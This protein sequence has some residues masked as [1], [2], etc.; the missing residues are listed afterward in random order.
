MSTDRPPR[1]T[2]EATN[3][4]TTDAP[5]PTSAP[6]QPQRTQTSFPT[7]VTLT[8]PALRNIHSLAFGRLDS[9]Y[10]A[11]SRVVQIA[12]Q[13]TLPHA[14]FDQLEQLT[15][16]DLPITRDQFTRIWKTLILK[17]VQDVHEKQRLARPANYINMSRNIFVPAP[18]ADLLRSLGQFHSKRLG[19]LINIDQPVTPDPLPDWWAYDPAVMA[20]WHR[21]IGRMQIAYQMEEYPTPHDYT[22]RP[23]TL[24]T[25]QD[26]AAGT[27]RTVRS[28]TDET[29]NNE[30]FIRFVNDD[31]FEP[32]PGITYDDCHLISAE[33][34]E[35]ST[36][37]YEYVRAYTKGVAQ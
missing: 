22:Q 6:P 19:Y 28:L 5:A 4:S 8:I 13:Q 14:V 17:R 12:N 3:P 23:I 26:I 24:T 29:S 36:I 10:H 31:L 2:P 33:A 37:I 35:R 11:L 7:H 16:V 1:P 25:F 21:C 18:L 15:S 34:I 30:A 27:L 20:L 32:T 9:D